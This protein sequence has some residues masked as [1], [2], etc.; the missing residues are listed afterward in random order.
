ML[1]N[2]SNSYNLA[3]NIIVFTGY[4]YN[5]LTRVIT[6]IWKNKL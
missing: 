1:Q 4:D 2:N 6:E 3:H 5:M